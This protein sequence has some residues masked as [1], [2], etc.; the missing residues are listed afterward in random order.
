M[1]KRIMMTM[2]LPFLMVAGFAQSSEAII[3]D[4]I[5]VQQDTLTV[6]PGIETVQQ[7]TVVVVDENL[8][9]K[10]TTI[11]EDN[12]EQV[13]T[14]FTDSLNQLKASFYAYFR[15]WEDMNIP[16][17]RHI[18]MN[19]KHYKL[20]LPPTYFTGPV[21]QAF[22][23]DWYPGKKMGMTM[24]DSL[25][26]ALS[27]APAQFEVPQIDSYKKADQWANRILLDYYMQYPDH[28]KGNEFY[29]EGLKAFDESKMPNAPRKEKV[30]EYMKAENPVASNVESDTEFIVIKPNFWKKSAATSL[31]FSQ[32]AIS[33]NWYKGGESTNALLGEVKLTANYDDKQKV[34]FENSLE[35]KIGFITAP[36]DTVHKYKTNADLFRLKSKLGVRAIKNLY[37]TLA[38]E[39]K[40]QFFSNY[41]TNTNDLISNF[42]SPAQLDVSLGLDYKLDKKK[43]NLS[44]MGSP[45]S[46][47]IV[48]I[49]DENIYDRGA[50]NVE[51]DKR[52]ANMFGSKVTANLDWKFTKNISWVSKLDYFTTYNKVIADWENTLNFQVS[53]YLSTKI[54]FHTRF[55]DGV[56]LNADNDSYFQFKEMLTF[57]LSYN[58]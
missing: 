24:T 34:Q 32:H 38:A 25:Y 44:L 12:R 37:Y 29:W 19:P 7:D 51:A 26:L 36:S 58:W 40:T 10:Y 16:T 17:P 33:E 4:T 11:I 48:Y 18:R 56:T 6:Q 15:I 55:D 13:M 52:V 2:I 43:Y 27:D 28:V 57:G 46:Y 50:F 9:L 31:Q 22:Q 8:T 5:T 14:A 35:V 41:K 23:V 3:Q 49:N 53:R 1:R 20:F 45:F 30:K 39:F 47:T 42:L 54:F 21:E